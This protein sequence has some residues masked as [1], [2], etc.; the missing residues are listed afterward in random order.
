MAKT[1]YSS[2]AAIIDES[3]L[4]R[5]IKLGPEKKIPIVKKQ[6]KMI[7][8]PNARLMQTSQTPFKNSREV[9]DN[10][11]HYAMIAAMQLLDSQEKVALPR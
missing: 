5:G 11:L 2:Q 10:N 4:L 6:K 8:I 1:N 9:K 7:K 3:A